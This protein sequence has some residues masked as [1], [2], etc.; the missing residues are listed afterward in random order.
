MTTVSKNKAKIKKE[1]KIQKIARQIQ[2]KIQKRK[3]TKCVGKRLTAEQK[4]LDLTN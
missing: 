3:K 1:K 2:R 4:K